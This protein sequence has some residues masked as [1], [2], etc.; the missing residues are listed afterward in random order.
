[1]N[2]ILC[3]YISSSILKYTMKKDL[4]DTYKIGDATLSSRIIMAPLTRCRAIENSKANDLIAKYYEQRAGCGLIVAEG[5]S[6]SPEGLGYNNIPGLFNQEQCDSWKA[7]TKAVHEKG[8]KIFLQFMHTGRIGHHYNLPEGYKLHGP[9]AKIARGEVST[10]KGR[11]EHP[12]PIEMTVDKIKQTV[13]EYVQ[14]AKYAIEAGFDGVEIHSAHGYLPNQ[15]MNTAS[16]LRTDEYG[17]DFEKNCKFTLEVTK[18]VINEIGANKV[19]IRISPFSPFE[20]REEK[21]FI[22]NKY[23]YLATELEKLKVGYIHFSNIVELMPEKDEIL[24]VIRKIYTGTL[25][26]CGELTKET[27]QKALDEFDVD[28]VGFGR[29]FIGNPDLVQR[30]KNNWPITERNQKGW[31]HGGEEGFTDYGFYEG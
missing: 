27:A 26:V 15:F 9:S 24:K 5:A 8:G 4:F 18:S 6:P 21:D 22:V 29:D 31:Y 16:N 14:A 23:T 7:A 20:K 25:I 12:M 19:G 28:L 11:Q 1:M 10:P 13:G 2:I 17:G 30:F 3:L